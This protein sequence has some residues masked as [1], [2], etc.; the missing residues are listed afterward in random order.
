[1]A[2]WVIESVFLR[3]PDKGFWACLGDLSPDMPRR[4]ETWDSLCNLML[5]LRGILRSSAILVSD[6]PQSNKRKDNSLWVTP[7][8][9]RERPNVKHY[10]AGYLGLPRPTP[11]PA[12]MIS[13]HIHAN[14]G[15][16]DPDVIGRQAAQMTSPLTSRQYRL[17]LS[18][19]SITDRAYSCR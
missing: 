6:S 3:S 11:A 8:I 9:P 2:W 17:G 5:K 10:I 7:F 1:M 16:A 19:A 14:S 18:Q 15:A 4:P 13:Q 12:L